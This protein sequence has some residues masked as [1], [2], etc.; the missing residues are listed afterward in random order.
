VDTESKA[1]SL[2]QLGFNDYIAARHL[3]NSKY[4][5]QG[6]TLASTALEKYLKVILVSKGKTKKDIG[7]HLDKIDKLKKHL[8]ECYTDFTN[9]I[10]ERFLQILGKAYKVRYYDDIKDPITIGFFTKQFL[11]E[12]DYTIALFENVIYKDVKDEKGNQILTLYKRNV[13]E[14]NPDLVLNNYL[15]SGM[16][17]KDFMEQ[18]DEGFCIY[19]NPHRWDGNILVEGRGIKNTYNGRITLINVNFEHKK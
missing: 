9:K 14:R 3:I 16:T 4:I 17:K 7:V 11:C 19:I 15:F 6:V 12:L 10:D 2:L 1:F 13:Q 18:V 5:L 8:D